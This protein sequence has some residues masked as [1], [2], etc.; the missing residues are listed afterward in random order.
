MEQRGECRGLFAGACNDD[1]ASEERQPFVPAQLVAQADYIANDDGGGWLERA[2]VNQARERFERACDH[3]L[4]RAR[5]PAHGHGGRGGGT[6][7][8]NDVAGDF[9]ELRKSHED[10]ERFG[11]ADLRPIDL[12]YIVAGDEGDD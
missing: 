3:F 8:C 2:L 4:I 7:A 10:D 6:S 1:A 5:A 11:G 12:P 9:I